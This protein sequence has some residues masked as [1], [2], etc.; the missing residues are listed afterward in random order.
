MLFLCYLKKKKMFGIYNMRLSFLVGGAKD[1][2]VLDN[3]VEEL[4]LTGQ[5]NVI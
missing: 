3:V 4:T 5:I 1:L 2:S